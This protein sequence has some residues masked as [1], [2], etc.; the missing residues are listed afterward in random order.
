MDLGLIRTES[1]CNKYK[2]YKQSFG[3]FDSYIIYHISRHIV[4]RSHILPCSC[5]CFRKIGIPQN[6]RFIM[7][8]PIFQWMIFGE[9]PPFSE[10]PHVLASAMLGH[11]RWWTSIWSAQP[12][13]N[14]RGS[15]L[16]WRSCHLKLDVAAGV[17]FYRN[18]ATFQE[19]SN[20]IEVLVGHSM[21]FQK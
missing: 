10:T 13:C 6:G 7:E 5:G 3:I 18:L 21:Q 20:K 19:R 9:N 2:C 1:F 16:V 17:F 8:N 11:Q 4:L 12:W 15:V 14:Q